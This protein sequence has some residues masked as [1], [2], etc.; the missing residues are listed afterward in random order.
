MTT[1]G[2]LNF[3][4]FLLLP[5]AAAVSATLV[6]TLHDQP[7]WLRT[8]TL[9]TVVAMNL[10]AISLG[11]LVSIML[12]R[13]WFVPSGILLAAL[14]GLLVFVGK[15]SGVSLSFLLGNVVAIAAGGV[16]AGRLQ[17]HSL[18]AWPTILPAVAGTVWYLAR[19]VRPDEVAPEAQFLSGPM[20]LVMG[21]VWIGLLAWLGCLV[22][23]RR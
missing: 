18:P 3:L 4:G 10:M 23:R 11:A 13:N 21:V 6:A 1:N 2:K 22:A 7:D 19:A 14:A 9:V 16:I 20:Y 15:G 12:I 17:P 5:V 8:E